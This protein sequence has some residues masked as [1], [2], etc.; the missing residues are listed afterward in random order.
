M[1]QSITQPKK[2]ALK[3]DILISVR[4]PVG[5]LNIATKDCA[6]GRGLGA[7]RSKLKCNSHLFYTLQSL[8]YHFDISDGEG[9]IFG[10]INKDELHNIQL[11][12]SEY[13]IK[14][15]EYVSLSIDTKIKNFSFENR[16]L[17]EL[18]D[19]VL[20]KLATVEG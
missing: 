17:A 20:S 2:K 8:K 6:I 19:L 14:N 3:D 4:A 18:K 7:L 1:R 11:T 15:F 5:D 10:S 13:E 9:T 16:K 12:Y